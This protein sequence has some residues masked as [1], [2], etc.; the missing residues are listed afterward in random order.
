MITYF[1]G[2]LWMLIKVNLCGRGKRQEKTLSRTEISTYVLYVAGPSN[3]IKV[4]I[5]LDPKLHFL[6]SSQCMHVY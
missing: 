4:E 1:W 6:P 3:I 2:H 5:M